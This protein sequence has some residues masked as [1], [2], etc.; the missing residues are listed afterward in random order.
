MPPKHEYRLN[1]LEKKVLRHLRRFRPKE[2]R[3]MDQKG[4]L[5]PHILHLQEWVQDQLP[6]LQSQGLNEVE[7]WEVLNERLFPPSEK[8]VPILGEDPAVSRAEAK[9]SRKRK[10]NRSSE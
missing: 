4:Q 7:A 10:V 9:R 5:L 1:P 3:A 2:S 6:L 8:D